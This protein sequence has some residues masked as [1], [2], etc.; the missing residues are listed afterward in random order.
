MRFLTGQ[1]GMA[2]TGGAGQWEIWTDDQDGRVALGETCATAYQIR[3]CDSLL[4]LEGQS[5]YADLIERMVFNALFGAQSPDGRRI[6]YYT[7]LEGNRE[8]FNQDSYCCPCNYRRIVSEL[9]TM[10]YYRAGKGLVVSLYT[11]S[12]ATLELAYGLSLKIR[13]E[14]DYPASGRVV[15][16][17]DPSKPATFP[18]RLR[19]PRWCEKATASINGQP[20]QQAIVSG[21]FLVVEREWKGGDQVALDM[22]MT[23]RLVLGRKRQ[24]GRV[25]VMRGPLV[26]CLNPAQNATLKNQDAADVGGAMLHPASLRDAPADSASGSTGVCCAVTAGSAG[27]NMWLSGDLSLRLTPFPDPNGKV[28]YFRLPDFSIAVPDELL[29]GQ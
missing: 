12:E 24:A 20:C 13:Q 11:P 14:T 8:Y 22:P 5:R 15:I 19:I 16:R 27:Y 25:A 2:I 4:R 21:D 3:L 17:L 7:P 23:W 6:R 28:V 29:S 9:P 18:V 1:D 10:V 26:Y